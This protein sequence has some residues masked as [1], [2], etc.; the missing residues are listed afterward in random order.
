MLRAV[1]LAPFI[2]CPQTLGPLEP[3]DGGYW[4]P[5]AER[6]YPVERGLVFMGYPARDA[7]MIQAT[8]EEERDY[9]GLGDA[10]TTN[11]AYLR[12]AAPQAVDFINT[13]SRFVPRDGGKPPRAL[14]LGCGNGWVSWLLAEAGFDTWMCDF[15]ANSLATGLNL[16]HPNLGEGK[17]F[18]TDARFTPIATG[19]VDLV[20]FKE[21]VH[22]V[23]DYRPLFR[24]ANRVLREGGTTAL[25]EPVRSLW[26]SVREIRHPDPHEG[27]HITW[28]D[29]YLRAISAAG[30][31]IVYQS[32]VY[33]ADSNRRRLMSSLKERAVKAIDEGRPSG[34]WFTKLHLRLIGG[35]QLVV[36]ARK[37]R[38][39]PA[40]ERPPMAQIDPA[41]LVAAADDLAGY[42]EFPAILRS[43]AERLR[44]PS[45]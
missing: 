16:E 12:E 36:V 9:Q 2:V 25:M 17:R 42:A 31:E 10:A 20:V 32:P 4:S 14:E 19:S 41:T 29:S 15:E 26:K 6:L 39:V 40:A 28:P 11:L 13:L 30:M 18:V 1:Q 45:A 3:A 37:A 5:L 34:N 22:H 7:A 27:H 38:E 24:E 43:A 21:F 35:A 8:M 33:M 44:S 23:A